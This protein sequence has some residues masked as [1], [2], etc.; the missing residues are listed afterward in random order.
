MA[1]PSPIVSWEVTNS[2]NVSR[3]LLNAPEG[4]GALGQPLAPTQLPLLP[5]LWP[6]AWDPNSEE[7]LQQG[8]CP[9]L[10]MTEASHGD[11]SP[12]AP[13]CLLPLENLGSGK[14]EGSGLP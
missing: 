5:S 4:T 6:E 2:P 13:A 11:S 7:T 14:A 12:Q 10:P 3:G 1:F 9:L 8:L